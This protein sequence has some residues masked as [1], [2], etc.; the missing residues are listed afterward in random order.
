MGKKIYLNP[1]HGAGGDYGACYYGRREADD[2]LLMCRKI[3]ERLNAQGIETR[4][5]RENTDGNGPYLKQIAEDANK[6]GP[7][8]VLICHRNAFGDGSAHG[9]ELYVYSSKTAA[10]GEKLLNAAAGA[11]GMSS[12]GVKERQDWLLLKDIA[13]PAYYLEYGF[14]SNEEDNAKFDGTLDACADGL[15]R[16]CVRSWARRMPGWGTP[17]RRSRKSRRKRRSS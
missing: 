4:M 10:N 6:W 1:G 5:S 17:S 15:Q 16:R 8:A 2:A 7:D 14:I 12:R 3:R 11:S 9:A 13:A